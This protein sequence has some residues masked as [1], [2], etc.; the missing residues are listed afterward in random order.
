MTPIPNINNSFTKK[1]LM[2]S[3]TTVCSKLKLS[4]D[5]HHHRQ[6]I[7]QENTS[8]D[9]NVTLHTAESL[10]E[11]RIGHWSGRLSLQE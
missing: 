4:S 11:K 7:Y 9:S 6:F 2:S 3:V 5:Y 1:P 8:H 10:S